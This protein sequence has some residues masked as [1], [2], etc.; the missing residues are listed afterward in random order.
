MRMSPPDFALADQ[1]CRKYFFT[2][3]AP[4][5]L[6]ATTRPLALCVGGAWLPLR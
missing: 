1:P 3:V 2:E 4:V 5:P 6:V